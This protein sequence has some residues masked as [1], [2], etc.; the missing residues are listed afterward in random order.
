MD[1]EKKYY[2]YPMIFYGRGQCTDCGGPLVVV[3]METSFIELSTSGSPIS[4]NTMISCE[5]VCRHCGKRIPMVRYGLEYI[6]YNEYTRSILEY[7]QM[8]RERAVKKR[9]EEAKPTEDN[10]FCINV[11]QK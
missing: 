2:N 4:E 3:D 1:E 10:P 9:M 5:A 11:A 8:I 7:N 6:P